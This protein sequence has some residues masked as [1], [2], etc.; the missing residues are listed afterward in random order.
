[1]ERRE[2]SKTALTKPVMAATGESEDL[3]T[4]EQRNLAQHSLVTHS[5]AFG[6]QRMPGMIQDGVDEAG[7][8]RHR[9]E[10]GLGDK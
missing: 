6:A 10:R 1:M 8:G 9:R 7:D 5:V 3:A 4:N 2:W